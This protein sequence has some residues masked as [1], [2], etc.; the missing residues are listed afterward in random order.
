MTDPEILAAAQALRNEELSPGFV[1]RDR[2]AARRDYRPTGP[3]GLLLTKKA[4]FLNFILKSN[5]NRVKG[6]LFFSARAKGSAGYA[7]ARPRA[8]RENERR[9]E[10]G[11][12]L[13]AYS[14]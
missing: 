2:E 3:P 5:D 13:D 9:G 7:G 12:R 14:T 11:K 1:A 6:R 10:S 8:A 4:G